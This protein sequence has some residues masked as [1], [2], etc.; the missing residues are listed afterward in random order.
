[1]YPPPRA[2]LLAW[3]KGLALD[4]SCQARCQGRVGMLRWLVC[5]HEAA[6]GAPTAWLE[7]ACV[8]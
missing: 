8:C 3:L 1:M 5:R 7:A 6:P 4:G 2:F